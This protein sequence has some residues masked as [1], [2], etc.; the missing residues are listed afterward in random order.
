MR[1]HNVRSTEQFDELWASAVR[2]GVLDPEVDRANLG[3]LTAL[4]AL[5]PG[6]F[7]LFA[8]P[9]ESVA[10]RWA[11]LVLAGRVRVEVWYS[12]VADDLVVYLDSLEII[13][14]SR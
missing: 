8:A 12:V 7:A 1:R 5:D 2:A 10:I 11:P 14:S 4:L 9:G 6:A 3:S 13:R